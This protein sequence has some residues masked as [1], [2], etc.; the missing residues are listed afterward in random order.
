MPDGTVQ[1]AESGNSGATISSIFGISTAPRIRSHQK[2]PAGT[3]PATL[4][5]S[6]LRP[7]RHR[8]RMPPT[9]PSARASPTATVR[10]WFDLR[11][12]FNSRGRVRQLY[13][14]IA[15][16]AKIVHPESIECSKSANLRGFPV[17]SSSVPSHPNPVRFSGSFT[18][19]IISGRDMIALWVV[20]F[21]SAC[22]VVDMTQRS[23]STL[24][25][26]LFLRSLGY[27]IAADG[28][29]GPSTKKATVLFQTANQ[30]KPDGEIGPRTLLCAREL[31]YRPPS[32]PPPPGARPLSPDLRRKLFGSF[33]F[34][35]RPTQSNPE[36]I[37]IL[38][39]WESENIVRVRIDQLEKVK[40]APKSGVPFHRIA[41]KQLARLFQRWD[42]AGLM[43]RVLTWDGS[44]VPRLIR[45]RTSVSMHAYGAAFDINCSW[46]RLGVRPA[47]LFEKGCV[48]ELVEIAWSHGFYW[49]G[50][51]SRRDG[52]H[53]EVCKIPE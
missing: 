44:F 12:F 1:E 22:A 49:G 31:G 40:G 29:L 15:A 45:G 20:D 17:V 28:V 25:W 16:E 32:W 37:S 33:R 26:Q 47:L 7:P 14:T 5:Q 36:A 39:D 4:P 23:E 48:R 50:W 11:G 21:R 53:F 43:D 41:A 42:D 2:T 18:I 38:G 8:K 35:R 6:P 52:M 46:N 9:S 19:G 24:A 51:F 13:T 30:L 3:S 27:T 34:L 10:S